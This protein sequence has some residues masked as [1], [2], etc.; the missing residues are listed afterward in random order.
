M[1]MKKHPYESVHVCGPSLHQTW[2]INK[3]LAMLLVFANTLSLPTER[4]GKRKPF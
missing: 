1:D 2:I 4:E 3:G